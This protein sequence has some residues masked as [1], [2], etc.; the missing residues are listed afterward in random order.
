MILWLSFSTVFYRK[1][2]KEHVWIISMWCPLKQS[3]SP[4]WELFEGCLSTKCHIQWKRFK[5]SVWNWITDLTRRILGFLRLIVYYKIETICFLST[6]DGVGDGEGYD[7]L[8]TSKIASVKILEY[9][10][11]GTCVA[12]NHFST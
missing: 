11:A 2:P 4:S 6:D 8:H 7:L 1:D 12:M 9:S 5:K 10:T 3:I